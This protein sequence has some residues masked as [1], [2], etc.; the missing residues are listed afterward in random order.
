MNWQ[1]YKK[2]ADKTVSEE[3]TDYFLHAVLGIATEIIEHEEGF[4]RGDKKNQKEEIGDFFWYVALYCNR[5]K[6]FGF[7]SE[8][9]SSVS[10]GL[11]HNLPLTKYYNATVVV[12]DLLDQAKKSIFYKVK[13]ERKIVCKAFYYCI[14]YIVNNT[15]DIEKILEHNIKKLRK[16]YPDKFKKKDAINRD[17]DNELSH[18]DE[19]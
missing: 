1:E 12:G 9:E 10:E 13:P 11:R 8:I 2:E 15:F 19:D 6:N 18:I 7:N 14:A 17:I 4:I 16:R 3:N 5:C